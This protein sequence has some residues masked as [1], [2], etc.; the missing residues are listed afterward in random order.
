[1]A[2]YVKWIEAAGARVAPILYNQTDAELKNIFDQL[3]GLVFPGGHCGFH[4]TAYGNASWYLQTLAK[5]AN[6]DGDVFPMWGTC[7]GFQQLAQFGSGQMEPS[8]LHRTA[9]TEGLL[10][11]VNFTDYGR[12]SSHLMQNAP[13]SVK[14][15]LESVPVTI[16]LHHYSVLT[17]V[18]EAPGSALHN[19]F[20]VVANNI[21]ANG[22]KFVSMI[23]ARHYPFYGTQFHGE[24][25]AFEWEQGW[26][27]NDTAKQAHSAGAVA[28]MQYLSSFFVNIARQSSH[29]WDDKAPT[30]PLIYDFVP[31][32]SASSSSDKWEL[33]YIF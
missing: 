21:D 27:G 18:V 19:F 31:V 16:N 15:T 10:V 30:L 5:A 25:N 9:G 32:P 8:V 14:Q 11:P 20:S 24:K 23:E 7:Q 29:V 33:V 22:T 12:T 2:S 26:E 28:A 4:G 6:D 3:S 1:M 17:S 13:A